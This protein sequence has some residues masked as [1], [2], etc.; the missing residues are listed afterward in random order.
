MPSGPNFRPAIIQARAKLAEGRAKLRAQHDRGS[1]GVQVC[2]RLTDLLD[3]VLLDLYHDALSLEDWPIEPLVTLVPHGGYGRRDVAPY[4]DVDL[5]LLHERGAA[6]EIQPFVRRFS[7]SIYDTGLDLGFSTRTPRQA[8]TLAL[9]D[10]TIFTS[11]VESRYLGGSVQLFARFF[12]GF[13]SNAQRHSASLITRIEEARREERHQYGETVY[14]LRPNVKRSRGGLRDLQLIRWVGFARYGEAEYKSLERAS[15]LHKEDRHRIRDAREFLLR[16]RNELHFYAGKPQ[17]QLDKEEQVRLAEKYEFPGDESVLPVENF[18][19]QYIEHTSDVR[20][21]TT[22]I[23][24]QAKQRLTL[25]SLLRPL[26]SHRVGDDF[27]VGSRHIS[28]TRKGLV[29]VCESLEGIL[30]LMDLSN[31]YNNRIDQPTWRAI[32]Q[33]MISRP[34]IDISPRAAEL[35]LSL[36]SQPPRLASLL[37]RLHELRALEKLVPAVTHARHLM[38]FNDYHKYA[39][40]EH[41]IRAVEAATSFQDMNGPLG[42]AYAGIRKKRTLHLALLIHDLGKGFDEDHSEVGRRLAAETAEHLGLPKHE[43]EILCFLVHKHLQMSHLAQRR[44]IHDDAVVAEFAF[45]VGSL[46]VLQMMYVLTCADLA[47]VGPGV[48]NSWKLDL[49]TQLYERTSEH[50]A[51]E[52][53]TGS[54]GSHPQIRSQIRAMVADEPNRDWWYAQIKAL[55]RT[56]LADTPPETII[57]QLRQLQDLSPTS[58]VAWGRYLPE[59]AAV[60]YTIGAHETITPGIFHK[61]TGALTSKGLQILS[62][63]I[64]PLTGQLVLD[65]FFVSDMDYSEEPPPERIDEVNQALVAALCNSNDA[66]PTFRRLWSAEPTAATE[67]VGLLPVQVR[68]DNSTSEQYTILDIFAHNQMGLLYTITLVMFELGLSVHVAKIGTYLDQVVDVF[69]VTDRDGKKILDEHRIG[70]IQRRIRL[71]L[72]ELV[73]AAR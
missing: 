71:A 23:L 25:P 50:L 66:P 55:P 38:Q 15:V 22:N 17:D 39:V 10:P 30:R 33:S 68:V 40:D 32:R 12:N 31:R 67:S 5:M 48:L 18:M 49:I 69:Y 60:E 2:A 56:Y 1:P 35:F 51:G 73:A 4:S 9:Q 45:D 52:S 29:K 70:E 7:Q 6:A 57:G 54:G 28:A 3:T 24:S 44:N 46:E 63:D 14:L 47:A 62:A 37:R 43:T 41:S 13:R 16:L 19:R 53:V 21:V 58:A 34:Q 61:L 27:R 42:A 59:R 64:H 11:L 20:Y 8:C 72:D 36:L 65:R 26:F